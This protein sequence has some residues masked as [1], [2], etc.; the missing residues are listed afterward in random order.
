MMEA[1]P[2]WPSGQ[3]RACRL[4]SVPGEY[5]PMFGSSCLRIKCPGLA[6]TGSRCKCRIPQEKNEALSAGWALRPVGG[7]CVE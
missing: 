6:C 1:P 7:G 2:I 3:V 5:C 4:G